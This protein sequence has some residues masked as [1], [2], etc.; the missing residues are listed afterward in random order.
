MSSK[1]VCI[2]VY[3]LG[4]LVAHL[5]DSNVDPLTSQHP[6]S[7]PASLHLLVTQ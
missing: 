4:S 6:Q 3:K 7:S 2:S 1:R 5:F